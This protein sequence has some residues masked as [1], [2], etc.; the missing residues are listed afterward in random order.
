[1]N[2]EEEIRKLQM[3]IN[4]LRVRTNDMG[5][6]HAWINGSWQKQPLLLGYSD[7]LRARTSNTNLSA[8]YNTLTL[9]PVPSGELW[10]LT[11]IAMQYGPNVSGVVIQAAIYDGSNET[12]LY[13]QANLVAGVYYNFPGPGPVI[14]VP[15]DY[16]RMNITGATAT[17]DARFHVSGWI[18]DTDQ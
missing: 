12:S 4:D 2:Y 15:G 10:V 16:L 6:N 13:S 14:L 1:M 8:G 18:V 7:V 5:N 3:Q 17:D 9:G 11:S